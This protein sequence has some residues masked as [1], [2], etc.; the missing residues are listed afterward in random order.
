[1]YI[2]ELTNYNLP[3]IIRLIKQRRVRWVGNVA[4]MGKVRSLYRILVGHLKGRGSLGDIRV[5]ER[6]II[7][8]S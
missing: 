6:K 4:D 7:N 3:Y 5:S 2:L 8:E 1:M